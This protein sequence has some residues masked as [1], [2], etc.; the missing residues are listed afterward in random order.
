MKV[1]KLKQKLKQK[2]P[3]MGTFVRMC[4]TSVE[5]LGLTGW[6]FVVIDMEHGVHSF[7]DVL[8]FKRTA[9]SVGI[10]TVVRIPEPTEIS[11]MRALDSGGEGVQVPQIKTIE[12]VH[13]VCNAARF[14]PL[15]NRGSCSY[16]SAASYA[17][18]PYPE[19]MK[20]SNEEVL[21]VIH[22]E[23]MESVNLIDKILEVP[24]VDVIF[25]GPWDLSQS[26]GIPGQTQDERVK[27]AIKKV[28]AACAKKGVAAGMFIN[29]PE[30][31]TEWVEAGVTYFTYAT[32]VGMYAQSVSKC[33]KDTREYIDQ[34]FQNKE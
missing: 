19:H 12:D 5:I 14:A 33:L 13:R 24:G 31:V 22:V 3:C 30:Q 23:N 20:T 8:T 10:S 34:Y 9:A 25:C 32:D 29:K 1:N 28:A 11:V 16:T 4:P 27:S 6:D 21:V 26:L 2:I 15:G 17:V 18:V 7:S